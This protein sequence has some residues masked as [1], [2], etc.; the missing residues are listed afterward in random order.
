[1]KSLLNQYVPPRSPSGRF[2]PCSP[3]AGG[4]Q[5]RLD[6]KQSSRA[7]IKKIFK[8]AISGNQKSAIDAGSG[9]NRTVTVLFKKSI[10]N[11]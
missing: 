11:A 10:K 9:S 3:K 7:N 8:T 4:A 2:S 5:I 1:M 6:K